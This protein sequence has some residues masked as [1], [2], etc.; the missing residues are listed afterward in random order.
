M[1][2]IVIKII[3]YSAT[4]QECFPKC[5]LMWTEDICKNIF[6]KNIEAIASNYYSITGEKNNENDTHEFEHFLV[7]RWFTSTEEIIQKNEESTDEDTT[8]NTD[9]EIMRSVHLCIDIL[10]NATDISNP[11][12]H[13]NK[14]R[15]NLDL[16]RGMAHIFFANITLN[17]DETFIR[18][19][20]TTFELIN[21]DEMHVFFEIALFVRILKRFPKA[22]FAY[23]LLDK[24]KV[25]EQL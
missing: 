25:N 1:V 10:N 13:K 12:K 22:T 23:L 5:K 19:T 8:I 2:L 3:L 6:K 17:Y 11:L 16:I 4:C 24:R 14:N 20:K 7:K 9:D 21:K 18:K 15:W